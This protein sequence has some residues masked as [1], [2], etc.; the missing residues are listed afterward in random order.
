MRCE[1]SASLLHSPQILFL[2][3]PTIGLDVI[4]K[5]ELRDHLCTLGDAEG[6]TLI[7]TSHDTADIEKVCQRIILID[8]GEKKRIPLLIGRFDRGKPITKTAATPLSFS[9]KSTIRGKESIG[10]AA[11]QMR[12]KI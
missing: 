10:K 6:T 8:K 12:V 7:L 9:A 4:T 3:E 5:T 1:I 2:D 11:V